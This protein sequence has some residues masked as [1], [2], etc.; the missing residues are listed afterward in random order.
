MPTLRGDGIRDIFVKKGQARNLRDFFGGGGLDPGHPQD[1]EQLKAV[2][3]GYQQG[4]YDD[5]QI[6]R[7]MEQNPA[8]EVFMRPALAQIKNMK[9]ESAR[10]FD[11]GSPAV[12]PFE[13]EF[14]GKG[15]LLPKE[16]VK[17]RADFQGA[18]LSA[19][20]RGDVDLATRLRA[21]EA[22]GASPTNQMTQVHL[23][24]RAKGG[25]T[26]NPNIDALSSEKADEILKNIQPFFS[27]ETTD[28][29]GG[30]ARVFGPRREFMGPEGPNVRKVKSG[31]SQPEKLSIEQR[32]AR[33]V[34]AQARGLVN[35]LWVA[36]GN[37]GSRARQAAELKLKQFTQSD[38]RVAQYDS[39]REGFLAPIIRALGEKGTLAE[40]DVGRARELWPAFTDSKEVANA[41]LNQVEKIFDGVLTGKFN[42]LGE[43]IAVMNKS[44]VGKRGTPQGNPQVRK[45]IGGKTYVK[46]GS[47]WFQ[48]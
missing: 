10:F 25:N 29:E 11:P 2:I 38:P 48:E 30:S 22:K 17:P 42:S 6:N 18:Q 14:A 36:E 33:G 23:A 28:P 26:G 4:V 41:K 9:A 19:L 3:Q 40:G 27:Y 45:T 15:A 37:V 34:I 8:T 20:N 39:L 43:A 24:V 5:E 21:L 13:G 1:A 31:Q 47:E 16:A 32:G 44:A 35:Q 7:F 46:R 12:T